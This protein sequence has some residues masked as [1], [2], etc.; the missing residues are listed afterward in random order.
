MET[1]GIGLLVMVNQDL[2]AQ[3]ISA[4]FGAMLFV[5]LK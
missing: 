2:C 5:R 1:S 3:L 4:S